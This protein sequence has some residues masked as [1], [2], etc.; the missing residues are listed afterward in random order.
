MAG[1]FFAFSVCVMRALGQLPLEQGIASMQSINVAI[2]NPLFLPF[3]S[4]RL[5]H[6]SLRWFLHYCTGTLPALVTFWPEACF[7]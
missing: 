4:A 3:S 2:L 7:I 6:A 1:F 5:P